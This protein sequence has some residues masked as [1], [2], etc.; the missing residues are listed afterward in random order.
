VMNLKLGSKELFR[1]KLI[2]FNKSMSQF[3][4][5]TRVGQRIKK[6]KSILRQLLN[7]ISD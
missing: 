5:E 1:S 3:W 7:I 4:A 2:S 6:L